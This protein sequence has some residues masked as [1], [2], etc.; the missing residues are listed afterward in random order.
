M[1]SFVNPV[2]LNRPVLVGN[3][4]IDISVGR[5]RALSEIPAYQVAL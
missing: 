1:I 3:I 5:M 4:E 2:S